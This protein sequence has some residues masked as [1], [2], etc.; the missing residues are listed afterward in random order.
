MARQFDAEKFVKAVA[1]MAPR[2]EAL[3]LL[4]KAPL[5]GSLVT[6]FHEL[7]HF[8]KVFLVKRVLA[9]QGLSNWV[10]FSNFAI[11]LALAW[12]MSFSWKFAVAGAIVTFTQP[13]TL[14]VLF[15]FLGLVITGLFLQSVVTC[16][17]FG[18]GT[19]R[20]A[21][22][23]STLI[24]NIPSKRNIFTPKDFETKTPGLDRPAFPK[25]Q[26]PV[27]VPPPASLPVM[28]LTLEGDETD[29]V[30]Q[31]VN[32]VNALTSKAHYRLD[33]LWPELVG[34][35]Y[36]DLYVAQVRNGGHSQF[37]HNSQA[38]FQQVLDAAEGAL[39]GTQMP[40]VSAVFHEFQKWCEQNPQK[41]SEQ[42]G[43]SGGRAP[44]LDELDSL[45]Y[46]ALEQEEY[47]NALAHWVSE[48]TFVTA[49]AEG[50]Y[51]AARDAMLN[52][53]PD[54]ER[55]GLIQHLNKTR[56]FLENRERLGA[57]LAL[58]S[59]Q[60]TAIFTSIQNGAYYDF[61]GKQEFAWR[62]HH[63]AGQ[64]YLR[65]VEDGFAYHPQVGQ[66]FSFPSFDSG[67]MQEEL[68]AAFEAYNALEDKPRPGPIAA[69]LAFSQVDAVQ[70][71]LKDGAYAD[72]IFATMAASG[73][74][75]DVRGMVMGRYP[76]DKTSDLTVL[77][78]DESGRVYKVEIMRQ[79]LAGLQEV[80]TGQKTSPKLFEI[81]PMREFVQAV[82]AA[83]PSP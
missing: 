9:E 22:S 55:R 83:Q 44:E 16:A 68:N 50:D 40:K 4:A 45:L 48:W 66:N 13:N 36:L 17:A 77:V 72:M 80:T 6:A 11:A 71:R 82:E 5:M 53:N 38:N 60:E 32:D 62:F 3:K 12:A 76:D 73:A 54:R 49:V 33:E 2:S 7:R 67:A 69:H 27:N 29:L 18:I 58:N 70:D 41:V 19:W 59:V 37:T 61:E 34:L 39:S 56:E 64:G 25:L 26:K 23:Q 79:S 1:A 81:T 43:F 42:T 63:T 14:G 35:Y 47:P 57:M 28:S 24:A 31:L 78:G 20:H 30:S 46:D 75:T 21:R 15:L 52:E 65:V 51:N 8:R 10:L 74:S